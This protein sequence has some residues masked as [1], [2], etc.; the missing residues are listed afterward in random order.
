MALGDLLAWWNLVFLFPGAAGLCLAFLSTVGARVVIARVES[1]QRF[2]L[3]V[4]VAE[5][6]SR[7]ENGGR[8]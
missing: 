7:I 3:V 6:G 2:C 8:S 1:D 4:E 5:E